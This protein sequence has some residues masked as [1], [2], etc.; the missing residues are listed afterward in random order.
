[1]QETDGKG[2]WCKRVCASSGGEDGRD[3]DLVKGGSHPD[4]QWAW[5]VLEAHHNHAALGSPVPEL[6]SFQESWGGVRRV[7]SAGE[8]F[9]LGI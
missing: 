1:M 4:T 5:W 3:R 2:E 9:N 8:A 6:V 7:L